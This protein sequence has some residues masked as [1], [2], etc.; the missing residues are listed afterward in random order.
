MIIYGKHAKIPLK[1]IS[2][3]FHGKWVLSVPFFVFSIM[4]AIK[5][6]LSCFYLGP[7]LL[8]YLSYL[9]SLF[10]SGHTCDLF[11]SHVNFF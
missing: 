9:V 1:N 4:H 5:D 10:L 2:C 7:S 8:K 3:D 6:F 11:R